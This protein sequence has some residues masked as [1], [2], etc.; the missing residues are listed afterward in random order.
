[1]VWSNLER[2]R[3]EKKNFVWWITGSKS[4]AEKTHKDQK[5]LFSQMEA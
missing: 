5:L 2:D 4:S 3:E 1:M